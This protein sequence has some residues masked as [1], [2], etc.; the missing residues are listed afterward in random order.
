MKTPSEFP[1]D[2]RDEMVLIWDAP[3][4]IFHWLL[5]LSFAGA[6]LTAES[7]R[8]RLVHVTLG[9]TLAGLVVF[10]LI[11]GL[12]GT[13]YARFVG[14]VRGPLAVGRYVKN[15]MYGQPEYYLGHNPVGAL[16]IVGLLSL[17]TL[18]VASGWSTYNDIGG[19]WLAELHGWVADTMLILVGIHIAGVVVTSWLHRERLVQAMFTGRKAGHAGDG[20]TSSWWSVGLALLAGVL[21]YWYWQAR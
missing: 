10:R 4:R 21:A 3:V 14:F 1:S 5:V 19:E 8:W 12:L 15:L 17:S 2:S 13:R 18:L 11:W 16:A 9:Y 6:Y 20:I 7:E